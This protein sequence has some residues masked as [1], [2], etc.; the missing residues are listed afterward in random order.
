[1]MEPEE[2]KKKEAGK[3]AFDEDEYGPQ[4]E[5]E[6]DEALLP[7]KEGGAGEAAA[8]GPLP[9]GA[10]EEG[11]IYFLYKPKVGAH[12]ANDLILVALCRTGGWWRAGHDDMPYACMHRRLQ[13]RR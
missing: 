12:H 6:P 13:C 4:S 2:A 10:L 3:A 8:T 11:H 9:E 1:M 7:A 5:S